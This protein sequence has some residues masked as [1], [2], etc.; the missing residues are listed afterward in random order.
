M[1]DRYECPQTP[2]H[3]H[4]EN[5]TCRSLHHCK[6]ADCTQFGAEYEF[7]RQAQIRRG[8]KLLIDATGTRRRIRALHTIGYSQR[9]IATMAG[10]SEPWVTHL[11]R[12]DK[13]KPPTAE[14]IAGI[15][16]RCWMNPPIGDTPTARAAI[17]KTKRYAAAAGWAGPLDWDDIDTDPEPGTQTVTSGPVD[18]E[19]YIDDVAVARA[20]AGEKQTLTRPEKVEAIRI[21][22]GR[23]WADTLIA[24]RLGMV[25][26]T[27]NRIRKDELKLPAWSLDESISRTE[28]A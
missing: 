9:A 10:R 8:R 7:W 26:D 21:A 16:S 13:V 2:E 19:P 27:V 4:G 25:L 18:E 14:L 28:A 22:H 24:A 20:L 17:T 15:Y 5:S 12:V 1:T 3:K 11:M 23:R 6:C